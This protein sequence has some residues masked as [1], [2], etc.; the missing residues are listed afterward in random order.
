MP[1]ITRR[2]S[3]RG[4]PRTSVGSSGSIFAHCSS[5]SQNRL[6]LTVPSHMVGGQRI[7]VKLIRQ[8]DYWVFTLASNSEAAICVS[9]KTNKA[10]NH[11]ATADSQAKCAASSKQLRRAERKIVL[12]RP[13]IIPGQNYRSV[14]QHPLQW[15]HSSYDFSSV[16][17]VWAF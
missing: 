11:R 9:S 6:R 4:L 16:F 15:P 2:S 3:T 10:A 14:E 17:R 8:Q 12:P 5:V 1:L 7:A 13:D